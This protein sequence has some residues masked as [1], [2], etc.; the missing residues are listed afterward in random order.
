MLSVVAGELQIVKKT[1]FSAGLFLIEL[2]AGQLILQVWYL[3]RLAKKNTID[4][5]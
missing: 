1:G 3:I 5:G 2:C 4:N